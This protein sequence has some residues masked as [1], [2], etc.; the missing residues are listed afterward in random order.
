MSKKDQRYFPLITL[1]NV[2]RF[3]KFFHRWIQQDK[4]L[5]MFSTTPQL[6]SSSVLHYLALWNLKCDFYHFTTTVVTKT[7]IEIYLVLLL[8][9]IHIICHAITYF[10]LNS[11]CLSCA[12]SVV[13]S[14]SS[15]ETM[16]QLNEC[17][18]PPCQCLP[19]QT[20]EMGDTHVYFIRSVVPT[21]RFEPT[22]LQN[23]HKNLAAGLCQKNS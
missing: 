1:P 14:L 5:V 19:L 21:P 2:C 13:S 11:N 17:T 18:Q 22:E 7:Y 9:V 15:S 16:C 10:W 4:T 3:S 20:S 6:R 8:N 23:L 12:R